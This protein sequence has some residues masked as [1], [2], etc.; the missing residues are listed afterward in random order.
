MNGLDRFDL[1][2]LRIIQKDNLTPQRKIGEMVNLSAAAVQR[3]IKRM[4]EN[5]V[6]KSDVS[7]IDPSLIGC[8]I[9]IV[10]EVEMQNDRKELTIHAKQKFSRCKQ[11]QQCYYVTG[12]I[13]FVLIINVATMVEY[14]ALTQELFFENENVNATKLLLL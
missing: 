12:D 10:V 13:D 2:I 7:V 8:P 6:I 9:T 1:E 3:R 14:E 5:G 11:V 4:H